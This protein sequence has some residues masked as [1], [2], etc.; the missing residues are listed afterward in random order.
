MV[1]CKGRNYYQ[2]RTDILK[3]SFEHS[4]FYTLPLQ[5]AK[6]LGMS[7]HNTNVLNSSSNAVGSV[8]ESKPL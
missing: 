6:T 1:P 2:S 4:K 8:D 7:K 5:T 3:A